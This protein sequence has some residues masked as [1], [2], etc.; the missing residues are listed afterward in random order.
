MVFIDRPELNFS[1]SNLTLNQSEAFLLF[2]DFDPTADPKQITLLNPANMY[3]FYYNY[4]F[5][6]A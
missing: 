4:T 2:E 3:E 1:N 6:L 5:N